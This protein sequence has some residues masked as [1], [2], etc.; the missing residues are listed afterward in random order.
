[1]PTQS[2]LV[3]ENPNGWGGASTWTT[4]DWSTVS[5]VDA[6]A[7]SATVVG[8]DVATAAASD[9]AQT[10]QVSNAAGFEAAAVDDAVAGAVASSQATTEVVAMADAMDGVHAVLADASDSSPS[11]DTSDGD[12]QA[13]A[14]A[15]DAAS[16]DDAP[17]AAAIAYAAQ[18][19]V[20]A[21]GDGAS[22]NSAQYAGS[23]DYL[24]PS[25]SVGSAATNF[26]AAAEG[27]SSDDASSVS[28]VFSPQTFET[29]MATSD[30][31]ATS[32][33]SAAVAEQN[34]LA[35]VVGGAVL[36]SVYNVP[37]AGKTAFRR[38]LDYP[39]EAVF[40]KDP[41]KVL[42]FKLSHRDRAQWIVADRVLTAYAGFVAKTYDLS[43]MT[44]GELEIALRA[45]GF[46]VSQANPYVSALSA[47]VLVEGRGDEAASYGDQVYA[48]T[49]QLWAMMSVYT[50]D[51]SIDGAT[52]LREALAQMLE[53]TASGFWLDLWASLF[54]VTRANGESDAKLRQDI[55]AEA[56]RLR[57]NALAIEKAIYDELGVRVKIR[58]PWKEMF[59]LDESLLSG[60]DA[61]HDST[62]YSPFYIQPVATGSVNWADV[63]KVIDR[64]RSA[65]VFVYD[66]I[67]EPDPI[68]VDAGM[69]SRTRIGLAITSDFTASSLP[70]GE[71]PL[72]EMVLDDNHFT[73]NHEINQYQL[74]SYANSNQLQPFDE[75]MPMISIAYATVALS[76][77]VALGD[78]NA[79]LSGLWEDVVVFNPTPATSDSLSLSDYTATE[80]LTYLDRVSL[81]NHAYGA[82]ISAITPT[83]AEKNYGVFSGGAVS[84]DGGRTRWA[85]SWDS[86]TWL[87]W[88][89][90]SSRRTDIHV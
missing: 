78:E 52:R 32:S 43:S 44:V 31:S 9:S 49:S 71:V 74:Q 16:G 25:D 27:M 82:A 1:M 89:S 76:D 6:V 34:S 40:S 88:L 80:Q 61:L 65:G 77:G 85:G 8:S 47:E 21:G 59:R 64:N 24:V 7:A 68:V 51:V 87:G 37:P 11:M 23:Q 57:C 4:G 50:D 81:E 46:T 42:A 63:L 69:M 75:M 14:V 29:G 2:D 30:G 35:D 45:D 60:T 17:T 79:A 20:A 26:G 10:Q 70:M 28:A 39:H 83:A 58:E 67:M 19:D 18:A 38:M 55:P 86:R 3:V 13:G 66:P 62:Y 90:V 53:P 84:Y 48:F 72:G 56:F 22:G 36:K 54:G 5:V 12:R 15:V 73:F 41:D 33:D